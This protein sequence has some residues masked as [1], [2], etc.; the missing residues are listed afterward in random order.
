M[1]INVQNQHGSDLKWSN[2]LR[3]ST[4]NRLLHFH[5]CPLEGFK[6]P[7]FSSLHVR[8][9]DFQYSQKQNLSKLFVHV[10]KTNKQKIREL[11]VSPVVSL[12]GPLRHPCFINTFIFIF[13]IPESQKC[14]M[15]LKVVLRPE[16]NITCFT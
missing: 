3:V 7:R 1:N 5:N 16:V 12:I 13:K 2:V 9:A 8:K 10:L 4:L 11:V 6:H 15:M 14:L